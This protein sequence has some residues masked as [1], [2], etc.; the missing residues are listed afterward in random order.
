M[1]RPSKTYSGYFV[2]ES[3][4]G[5]LAGATGN[6]QLVRIQAACKQDSADR[7]YTV[8]NEYIAARIG[9]A[10][11][12]PV[13]PGQLVR[14]SDG[15]IG[16]ICL[17]FG[18][19]GV[20]LPPVLPEEFVKDDP[21]LAIGIVMFDMW[22]RNGIDRHEENLA[23]LPDVGGVI[24]DHDTALFGT[25]YQKG[26]EDLRNAINQPCLDGHCLPEALTTLEHAHEWSARFKAIPIALIREAAQTV[27]RL[28]LIKAA[29][30]DVVVEFLQ[31]RRTRLLTYLEECRD[32]F[33]QVTKWP[34]LSEST[35]AG[36]A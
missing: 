9:F 3:V 26:A 5:A 32:M 33:G 30:R 34:I 27:F 11:G 25:R 35:Q 17:M 23:H 24:F 7:P 31:F 18:P 6:G 10:A 15:K 14:L 29:E 28:G 12:L 16:Y 4:A 36:D 1:P 13:P 19:E 21:H 22:I 8:A 20:S 2:I